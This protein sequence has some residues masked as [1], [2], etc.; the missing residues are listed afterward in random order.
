MSPENAL[1][2]HQVPPRVAVDAEVSEQ[3][4][5]RTAQQDYTEQG[6]K[7]KNLPQKGG[8]WQTLGFDT[9]REDLNGGHNHL[10]RTEQV[11]VPVG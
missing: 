9:P 8:G 3:Q 4:E 10:S 11:L 7:G 6:G 5:E 2:H 1:A